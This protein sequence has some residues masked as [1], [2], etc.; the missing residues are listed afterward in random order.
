MTQ[1]HLEGQG[2][3]SDQASR[4]HSDTPQSAGLLW[5]KDR[6]EAKPSTWR[7]TTITGDRHPCPRRNSKPQFQQTKP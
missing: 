7:N 5:T 1:Q 4:S 2:L 6:T 3:L